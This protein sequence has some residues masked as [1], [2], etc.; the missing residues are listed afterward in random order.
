M[1][2]AAELGELLSYSVRVHD[3][4]QREWPRGRPLGLLG[5]N[6]VPNDDSGLVYELAE[7]G[8]A[9]ALCELLGV[10]HIAL[11]AHTGRAMRMCVAEAA[12]LVPPWCEGN[13]SHRLCECYP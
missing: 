9:V 11:L 5:H 6:D 7:A 13:F 10:K 4:E 8:A 1:I 3:N 2:V 12:K